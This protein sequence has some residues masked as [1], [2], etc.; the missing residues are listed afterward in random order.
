MTVPSLRNA[1]FS[2]ASFSASV[3][4]RGCSSRSSSPAGTS[5]S[6]K[7]PAA[8][9]AAQRRCDSS[10]NASWSSRE[11]LPALGDVLAG[12][13]HRLEREHLLHPRVREAPAERGVPDGLIAARETRAPAC[14]SRAA[15]ASS[16]RRRPRRTGRRPRAITAWQA[17]TTADR[18]EA[19][20][21]LTVTPATDSRQPGE[22]RAHPRDVAVVLAG[23]VRAAEPDVLDL[24]RRARRHA[25]PP[26]RSRSPRGRPA[27]PRRA[28]R[29]S[30]R[31]A[32]GRR[33]GSRP[34]TQR[35]V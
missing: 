31:R 7:R 35:P 28:R 26:R 6:A 1:G 22:Q 17:P 15:R 18:P 3:S 32:C 2:A 27:A 5:S 34:G 33:R 29:R 9:A 12:L 14:P 19:Q 10:A 23:L 16:T 4:G 30:G 13:A 11:T 25:R 24:A 8:S 20:S 21:R